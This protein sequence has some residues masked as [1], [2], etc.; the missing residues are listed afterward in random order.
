MSASYS[1][2]RGVVTWQRSKHLGRHALNHALNHA[3]AA[4]VDQRRQHPQAQDNVSSVNTTASR[5]LCE[6]ISAKSRGTCIL[7]FSRG[8]DSI[9]A[10]IQIRRYFDRIIPFHCACVPGMRFVDE[11]LDYYERVFGTKIL[12]LFNGDVLEDINNLV[13]QPPDAVEYI[14]NNLF[15]AFTKYDIVDRIRY[16]YDVSYA[17]VAWGISM[18]DSITRRADVL[19]CGGKKEGVRSFYPCFDWTQKMIRDAVTCLLPKDYMWS[20][21]TVSGTPTLRS[22]RNMMA[23]VPDDYERMRVM[24]PM[25]EA[26]LVRN[27]IR[28]ERVKR[29]E[30]EKE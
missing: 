6:E 2:V 21:R 5:R 30:A 24:F 22:I 3:L 25:M 12:R 9:A 28:E 4:S 17:W 8:K 26:L 10:W 27:E 11:S 1:A 16:D 13:F 18:Y 14:D 23:V 15:E 7:G 19:S 20:Q 29:N